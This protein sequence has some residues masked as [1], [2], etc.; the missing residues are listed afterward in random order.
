MAFAAAFTRALCGIE[1]PE[2]QVEVHLA[3]GLPMFNL[4]GLPEAAV[5][6]SRI[7]VRSAI[8]NAGFPFPCSR[9]SANLAPADLPK[10]GTRFDLAIGIAILMA[11]G[12]AP[13]K[14]AQTC[15]FLGELA[16]DGSLRPI[17]GAL[18]A[19]MA[20]GSDRILV[21]HPDN[22]AQAV[23]VPKCRI[24]P[25]KTLGEL[26]ALLREPPARWALCSPCRTASERVTC[27]VPGTDTGDLAEVA[28]QPAA[29]RALEIAAA[30]GHNLLMVGPP[31]TGKTM[32]ATRLPGILPP[33]SPSE[34]LEVARVQGLKDPRAVLMQTARPFRAPHHSITATALVGG[35]SLPQPGEISLAHKGVLFLDELAEFPQR[36][37]DLLRQ[38][39]ESGE[40]C[41]ARAA[42]T[43]VF[44]AEFQL[45]AAMNPCP[46]GM[47]DTQDSP[48]CCRPT[49]IAR[50]N[51]RISGPLLDRIDCHLTL[52]RPRLTQLF[53]GVSGH[54]SEDSATV[55]ERVVAARGRQWQRQSCLN[56]RLSDAL[57]AT[58]TTLSPADESMLLKAAD[59]MRLSRRAVNRTLRVARS[60]ADLAAV[61]RI[62]TEHLQEA[63]HLRA[64]PVVP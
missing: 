26:V 21:M 40:V 20:A 47:A 5:R 33:L 30:G 12:E 17:P 28:G 4:V 16:L 13:A 35:G 57:L 19:T 62:Q 64:R 18:A 58:H 48:C 25:V 10:E 50:Y 27:A 9:I 39:L 24:L 1:A 46:C 11:A 43:S 49:D 61:T 55:R 44:P 23:H 2:V 31:G 42:R 37:L 14:A 63:L 22:A 53:A 8:Q 32:L 41:I 3:G 45:I 56:S 52:R 15:E 60:I 7:R 36:T 51:N 6:E 34:Q 29:R 38:P 54:G 59:R